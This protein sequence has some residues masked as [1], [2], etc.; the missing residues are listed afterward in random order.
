MK[1]SEKEAILFLISSA[2]DSDY[3]FG[4][5]VA[6]VVAITFLGEVA[7][8]IMITFK[9]VVDPTLNVHTCFF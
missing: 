7:V 3:F 1:S 5:E 2:S 4:E 8:E 9:K 6:I